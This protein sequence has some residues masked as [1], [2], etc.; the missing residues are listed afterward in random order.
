MP[1]R[2]RFDAGILNRGPWVVLKKIVF[3]VGRAAQL[4]DD[5]SL[6][7]GP[8]ADG[9]ARTTR[10][11]AVEAHGT[12]VARLNQAPGRA[13]VDAVGDASALRSGF[14]GFRRLLTAVWCSFSSRAARRRPRALGLA[15]RAAWRRRPP[16]RRGRPA[17]ALGATRGWRPGAAVELRDGGPA[18][19]RAKRDFIGRNVFAPAA[20]CA[21]DR[22]GRR[23]QVSHLD[24]R[25]GRAHA[26]TVTTFVVLVSRAGRGC[27][28]L[29]T[30][31]SGPPSAWRQRPWRASGGRW[32]SAPMACRWRQ[33][34][35][36]RVWLGGSLCAC[37]LKQFCKVGRAAT[38]G[39]ARRR[40]ALNRVVPRCAREWQFKRR[41]SSRG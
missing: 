33:P 26:R 27:S 12:A 2:P 25:H 16:T 38:P 40:R 39:P 41:S 22:A 24:G 10:T 21:I 28:V 5:G 15:V 1:Y 8:G 36:E 35:I 14:F 4:D 19:E 32:P 7:L 18:F 23:E 9:P 31:G 6:R 30:F 3:F 20:A 11:D 29:A 17:P 13:L 34:R 37:G